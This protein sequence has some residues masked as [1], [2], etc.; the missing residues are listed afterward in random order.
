MDFKN[1]DQPFWIQ[2]Q[3]FSGHICSSVLMPHFRFEFSIRYIIFMF[4]YSYIDSS[5]I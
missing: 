5:G 4:V 2:K 1:I 3:T